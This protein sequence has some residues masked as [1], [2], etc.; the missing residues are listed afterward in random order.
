VDEKLL[1]VSVGCFVRYCFVLHEMI[2][3]GHQIVR[4]AEKQES[5]CVVACAKVLFCDHTGGMG[6][7]C[8]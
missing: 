2:R 7:T 8:D 6:Q 3:V 4:S 1:F 5:Y